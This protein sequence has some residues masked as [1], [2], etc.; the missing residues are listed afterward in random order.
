MR[1]AL[2]S[3]L[4]I[5]LAVGCDGDEPKPEP[6]ED[7]D[8]DADA[9]ADA[10]AD[11][12][13]DGGADGHAQDHDHKAITKVVLDITSQ[14]DGSEQT[15][16]FGD[17]QTGAGGVD[18]DIELVNGTTYDMAMTVLNDLESPIL[19]I[20]NEIIEEANEYQVFFTGS[21][22]N[23]GIVTFTYDDQDDNG[24]PLGFDSTLTG[25]AAGSG[26]LT[27]TLQHM[28]EQDGNAVKRDGMAD[29]VAAEGLAGI[30]G[31]GAPEVHIDFPVTV[32]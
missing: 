17:P 23:D 29:E 24:L 16:N 8:A 27:L 30:A 21:A 20:T 11:A 19:D 4:M 1:L 25:A 9:G 15:I 7:A 32:Q 28:P 13:A 14:A 22:I 12:D 26:I 18:T 10:D 6:T 3:L 31:E 5:P 2:M